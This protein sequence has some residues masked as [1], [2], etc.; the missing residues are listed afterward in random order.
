MNNCSRTFKTGKVV[1]III[2]LKKKK[3]K[4]YRKKNS[5]CMIQQIWSAVLLKEK[6]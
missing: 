4:S 1:K 2:L 6:W 3:K 5:N